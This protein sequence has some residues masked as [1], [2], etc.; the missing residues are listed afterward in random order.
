MWFVHHLGKLSSNGIY[1]HHIFNNKVNYVGIYWK[2]DDH[3]II[4][5]ELSLKEMVWMMNSSYMAFKLS[6]ENI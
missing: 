6:L 1:P 2:N 3:V 4:I 5:I